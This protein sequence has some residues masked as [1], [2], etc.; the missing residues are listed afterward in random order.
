[1]KE[2]VKETNRSSLGY[3]H[4][5]F[6]LS[7][8][9]T[10]REDGSGRVPFNNRRHPHSPRDGLSEIGETGEYTLWHRFCF[11]VSFYFL[12]KYTPNLW[13]YGP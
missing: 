7:E 10:T 6:Q 1:M 13:K 8:L 9:Q 2:N 12:S 11:L 5:T 3:L 4:S